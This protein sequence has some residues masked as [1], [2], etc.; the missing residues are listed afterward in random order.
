MSGEIIIETGILRL[1]GSMCMVRSSWQKFL[2]LAPVAAS[3]SPGAAVTRPPAAP[4]SC[5][6]NPEHLAV[7]PTLGVIQ[8]TFE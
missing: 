1:E 7:I 4:G 3:S 5:S 8:L 2:H 6:G